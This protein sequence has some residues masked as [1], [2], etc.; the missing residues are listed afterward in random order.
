MIELRCYDCGSRN[1][2]EVNREDRFE[3]FDRSIEVTYSCGDCG[4]DFTEIFEYSHTE[5]A[6]GDVIDTHAENFPKPRRVP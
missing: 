4:E 2:K 1:V 5:D 6:Q 3:T